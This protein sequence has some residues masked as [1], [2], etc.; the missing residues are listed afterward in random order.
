MR[1]MINLPGM[2]GSDQLHW[3]T[4]WEMKGLPF[5]R[6]QP[7][8]WVR[9]ELNDW[10]NALEREVSAASSPPVLVAHS[11]SC[12]L[13]AHWAQKTQ[14]E[15]RGAFLVAVPDPASPAFPKSATAFGELQLHPLPF[16]SMVI[17]STNDPYGTAIYACDR[18][19]VWE[20]EYVEIGE[21]GH[22]NSMSGLG[23]W[24]EGL[25]LLEGFWLE[26]G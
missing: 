26:H 17:A 18:A 2:G 8:S 16:P 25:A 19:A 9:P 10:L 12:L 3:Q 6:F 24:P 20:S 15:I 7:E 5:T 11:L 23:D 13:I 4:R 1:N 14:L 22:I 21:C